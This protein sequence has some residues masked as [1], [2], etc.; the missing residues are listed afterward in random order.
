MKPAK[1]KALCDNYKYQPIKTFLY[2]DAQ[3]IIYYMGLGGSL[4]LQKELLWD[5]TTTFM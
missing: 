2:V 3:V 1:A 5:R 4:C